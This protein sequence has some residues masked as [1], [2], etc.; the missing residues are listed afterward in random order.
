MGIKLGKIRIEA[1]GTAKWM[2]G[3]EVFDIT[4]GVATQ[5]KSTCVAIDDQ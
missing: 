3:K 1:D 5:I 2:A 4:P